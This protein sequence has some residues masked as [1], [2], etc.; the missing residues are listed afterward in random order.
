M[1]VSFTKNVSFKTFISIVLVGVAISLAITDF[2]VLRIKESVELDNVE[3]IADSLKPFQKKIIKDEIIPSSIKDNVISKPIKISKGDN[4]YQLLKCASVPLDQ[5]NLSIKAL[6]SVFD[7]KN[8]NLQ[9]E[10][11]LTI[12]G[13]GKQCNLL[14]MIIRLSLKE[15]IVVEQTTDNTFIA[16]KR[17]RDVKLRSYAFKG[18]V[19]TNLYNDASNIGVCDQALRSFINAFGYV[20]NF[21]RNIHKGDEFKVLYDVVVDKQTGEESFLH[22]NYMALKIRSKLLELFRH[23]RDKG[24]VDYYETT[25]KTVQRSLL[26]MPVDGAYVSSGY[27]W[28]QTPVA[29]YKT[30]HH[31]VDFAAPKGTLIR[32]AG[33]GKIHKI[34]NSPSYGKVII[35]N[36]GGDKGIKYHT[37]YAHMSSFAPSLR[38][39]SLVSQGDPIGRVGCTGNARGYHLHFEVWRN[40]KKI[41]PMKVKGIPVGASLKGTDYK[42]FLGHIKYLKNNFKQQLKVDNNRNLATGQQ[43]SLKT[44]LKRKIK[45]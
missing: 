9:H 35:I 36:H 45:S 12:T 30:F 33:K 29:D 18:A 31:G 40:M 42:R 20:V 44:S 27:G 25:G 32:A 43:S 19:N 39:N 2:F 22:V 21:D 24:N 41:N 37:L 38:K 28:R 3:R 6:R 4:L 13:T 16:T 17:K 23:K 14:S 11:L 10:L 5:I 8:L 7:P 34:Y 26:N 1:L 15:E